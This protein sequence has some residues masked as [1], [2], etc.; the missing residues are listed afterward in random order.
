MNSVRNKFEPLKEI[1]KDNLHIFLVSD[2][3]F[4][5]GQF[6]IDGDSTLYCLDRTSQGGRILQYI[7]ED[8]PCKLLIFKPAQN[9]FE[10]FFVEINLGRKW[11][12]FPAPITPTEI[13][14]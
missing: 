11:V 2:V 8:I 10:G 13:I 9:S 6:C 5:V 14:L 4:L 3:T 12:F 7:R 1:I